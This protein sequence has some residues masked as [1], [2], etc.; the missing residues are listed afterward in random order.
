[1]NPRQFEEFVCEHFRQ[2][3]YKAELTT[4]SNDYG[5]DGF[6]IKGKQ[7]IAIQSKMYGHTTRKINRQMVMELHGAKDFFD[8]TKAVIATDGIFLQDALVVAEKLKIEILYL[9]EIKKNTSTSITTTKNKN[10]KTFEQIW[11]DYIIPL[12]GKTLIRKNGETNQIIKADWSGI[13]RKTSNG[14]NGKIKIEIFKQAVNRLLTDGSITRDY[15]NQNYVG[16]ASS[17]IILVLSQVPFFKLTEK[18]TGLKYE[19]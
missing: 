11:E 10:N 13:E 16:R 1:M 15:I 5:I 9:N 3:G 4:Y 19:K 2:Q 12:Q 18:P 17:G 7:K 8:C 14:N 6:A